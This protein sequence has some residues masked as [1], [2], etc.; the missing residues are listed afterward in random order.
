MASPRPDAT[1]WNEMR[2]NDTKKRKMMKQE[3]RSTWVACYCQQ[4]PSWWFMHGHMIHPITNH[5]IKEFEGFTGSAF[6]FFSKVKS[7]KNRKMA[8]WCV[9][10]K[11][12]VSLQVNCRTSGWQLSVNES[13]TEAFSMNGPC[14]G[15][16]G[17]GLGRPISDGDPGP[18]GWLD[19]RGPRGSQIKRKRVRLVLSLIFH[20]P[21]FS[22]FICRLER[23]KKNLYFSNK[24]YRISQLFHSFDGHRKFVNYVSFI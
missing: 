1:W 20:I 5:K 17:R 24:N 13:L 15:G 4:E 12:K 7:S 16:R 10:P 14:F 22:E 11:T 21:L 3:T 2:V 6:S 23:K 18:G 9:R 19:P 8:K